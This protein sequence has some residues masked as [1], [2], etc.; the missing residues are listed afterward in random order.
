MAEMPF[1]RGRPGHELE[2]EAVVE[3]REASRGEIEAAAIGAPDV[4]VG[5]ALDGRPSGLGGQALVQCVELAAPQCLDQVAAETHAARLALGQ[6]LTDEMLGAA[7]ERLADLG[8][9]PSAAERD[10]FARNRVA[11]EPGGAVRRDLLLERKIRSDGKRDAP[12]A[13]GIV[14]LAQLDDRAWGGI[15]GRVEIGELDVVGAAVDA[16]DDR[17]GAALE[18]VS[19]PR[20]SKRPTIGSSRLS[21]AST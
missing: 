14:E 12:A 1:K 7:V 6:A 17:V 18:L 10:R 3:H 15:P 9:E 16:V 2:A 8:A 20:A 11:V 5:V 13:L 4:F 19:S 21:P